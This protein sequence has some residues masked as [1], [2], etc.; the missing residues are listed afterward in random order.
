MA[1]AKRNRSR[2]T[3]LPHAKWCEFSHR[4]LRRREYANGR[5]WPHVSTRPNTHPLGLT[6]EDQRSQYVVRIF[7]SYVAASS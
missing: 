1:L 3:R 2:A 5:S 4:F 6:L 7:G